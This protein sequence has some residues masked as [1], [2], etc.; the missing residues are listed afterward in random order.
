M[1]RYST[2][3]GLSANIVLLYS[4]SHEGDIV[5]KDDFEGMAK[6]NSNLKVVNTITRPTRAWK[7]LTGRID[8]DMIIREVPDYADRVFFTSGPRKMVEATLTLLKSLSLP[9]NQIKHEYFSGYD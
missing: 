4:N 7:G 5:S 2:D 8:L 6:Q 3:K 1:I 9:E